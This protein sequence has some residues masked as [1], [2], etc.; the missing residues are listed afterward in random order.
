M[1]FDT[2][3]SKEVSNTIIHFTDETEAEGLRY[4]PKFTPIQFFKIGL[5]LFLDQNVMFFPIALPMSI[6]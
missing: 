5:I 2:G 1:S 3:K 6:N 4:L